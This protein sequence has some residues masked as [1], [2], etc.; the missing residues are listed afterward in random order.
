M[1]RNRKIVIMAMTLLIIVILL[2]PACKKKN[3]LGPGTPVIVTDEAGEPVTD[4]NGEYVTEIVYKEVVVVT[5]KNGVPVTDESGE[6]ITVVLETEI[7]PVTNANGDKVYD[8]NGEE[9]TSIKYFPQEIEIP[10]T[11]SEGEMVTDDKG[12]IVSTSIVV[13]PENEIIISELP[14]TDY[15]GNVAVDKDGST[16]TYT[17]IYTTGS[18]V[19]GDTNSSNWGTTF[20][21][22]SVDDFTATAATPDGG[23]V[24]LLRTNSKDGTLLG[25]TNDASVPYMLLMKFNSNGKLQWQK[26][27]AG[28]GALHLNSLSVDKS[29]NIYAG[30]YSNSTNLGYTRYGDYDAV[31][32]KFSSTGDTNWVKNFGGKMTDS[33]SSVCACPDGTI[34]AVGM[35]AS[36]DGN[37]SVLGLKAGTSAAILVKYNSDGEIV[38]ANKTGDIGDSFASVD[39]AND[40]SI[41]ALGNFSSKKDNK[42]FTTYGRADAAIV[43]FAADGTRKWVKQY[44]GS[45][46]ENFQSIAASNDGCVICGRSQSSD[47]SLATLGNQGGYDAIA[48]KFDTNGNPVWETAF[49]GVEDDSFSSVK[50]LPDGSYVMCGYSWSSTRDL[51]TI[52]NKGMSDGFVITVDKDGRINSIQGYGGTNEDQFTDLCVLT[53]GEY[54]VCGATLSSNGDLVGGTVESDGKSTVG[55]IAKFK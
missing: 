46:I 4:K 54:I 40:G 22:S 11:N 50:Q 12:H 1:N 29:G 25:L 55:M 39:V 36:N 28:N 15:V 41:Y 9:K 53:N 17:I 21:G 35:S 43:K 51:K 10:L 23:C 26:A 8:E 13:P 5:D 48:V 33:F 37:A 27:I 20:G 45:K 19:P 44:G 34:V 14:V 3:K 49:R 38:Y 2:V 16:I 30:G 7:V 32:Y 42:A 52:G 31:L 24:A 6:A 18:V 47:K